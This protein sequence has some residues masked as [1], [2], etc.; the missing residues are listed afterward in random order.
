MTFQTIDLAFA[1]ALLKEDRDSELY[2]FLALL[3]QKTREGHLCLYNPTIRDK[4]AHL[5]HGDKSPIVCYE[6]HYYLRRMFDLETSIL[7]HLKRLFYAKPKLPLIVN[8]KIPLY[9]AQKEALL[10]AFT[11][12]LLLISGGPGSGKTYLANALIETLLDERPD[13]S[14]LFTAPTGK[15]AFRIKHPG[16]TQGTLHNLLGLREKMTKTSDIKPLVYD[17]IIVDECSMIDAKLFSL[18][19]SSIP[20]GTHLILI[21]DP[22]Q[23]P[24]VEAG[25]VFPEF[26]SIRDLPQI[27]LDQSMRSDRKGILTLAKHIKQ[28]EIDAAFSLLTN[29]DVLDVKLIPLP[30]VLPIPIDPSITFLTPFRKGPFGSTYCNEFIESHKKHSL[31]TPLI[32]TK[33]DY[34]FNLMNGD[35]GWKEGAFG[36]FPQKVNLSL[37]SEYDLAWAIS[38]HKSQGSEFNHVLVLLP[39]GS[40]LFGKEL[41]YT[42]VTRAK[43][44]VTIASHPETLRQTLLKTTRPSSNIASRW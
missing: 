13:A 20:S 37:L 39:E 27:H 22:D 10:K 19:L 23:L 28:N 38:I 40:D 9:D 35:M 24:P 34:N 43:Q 33:N 14:I 25:F 6:D 17:F 30:K 41:I 4:M 1:G 7:E 5:A 16:I 11:H 26:F 18:F 2:S 8:A 12:P 15:A 42:A 31:K 3:M 44:S 29:P 21:G 36:L 32:V